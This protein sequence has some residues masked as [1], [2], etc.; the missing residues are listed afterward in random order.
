MSNL[1]LAISTI[2]LVKIYVL[3]RPKSVDLIKQYTALAYQT[4][5]DQGLNPMAI[6]IR[7]GNDPASDDDQVINTEMIGKGTHIASHGYVESES[8]W[9][10]R[11]ATYAQ[12]KLDSVLDRPT[13]RPAW[14]TEKKLHFEGEVGLGQ[15][16]KEGEFGAGKEG[17]AENV[18]SDTGNLAKPRTAPVD[19]YQDSTINES[20]DPG[21]QALPTKQHLEDKRK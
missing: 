9:H 21:T 1:S 5:T 15:L 12:D 2:N 3:I 14:S 17:P 19:D 4:A 11:D 20:I 8:D 16:R 13:G 18:R 10:I 7:S 6:F